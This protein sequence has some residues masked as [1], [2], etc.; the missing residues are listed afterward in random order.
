VQLKQGTSL[1]GNRNSYHICHVLGQNDLSITYL[2]TVTLQTNPPGAIEK[3]ENVVIREFFMRDFCVRE[4]SASQV[5]VPFAGKLEVVEAFR[6]RFIEEIT[7]IAKLRHPN[8]IKVIDIFE[9]N[10]SAY[11]VTEY[12]EG[13]SLRK[14]VE[15]KGA[16][17]EREALAC[18][19][20]AAYAL[21]YIHEQRIS[22]LNIEP[23]AII[24]KP[25]NSVVL[26]SFGILKR[27]KTQTL[28]LSADVSN[29]Y[30]PAEQNGSDVL[31]PCSV[32]TDVYSLAATLYKLLTTLAPPVG[33]GGTL[34]FPDHISK[35]VAAAIKKAM[36]PARSKRP[37]SMR[38]FLQLLYSSNV[39]EP[40]EEPKEEPEITEIAEPESPSLS[41]DKEEDCPKILVRIK[42]KGRYGYVDTSGKKVIPLKYGKA[43]DFSDGLALVKLNNKYC[44]IDTNGKIVISLKYDFIGDFSDG[45]ALVKLNGKYGYIDKKGRKI[46]SPKYDKAGDFSEGFAWVKLH[47]KYGYIN[48]KGKKIISLKYDKAGNFSEGIAWVRKN[49]KYGYIDTKGRE[50]IPQKYDRAG[51]FARGLARVEMDCECGY[52]DAGGREVVPL[53]YDWIWDFTGCLARAQSDGKYLWVDEQGNEYETEEEGRKA[54]CSLLCTRKESC[55]WG[56]KGA[57]FRG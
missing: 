12:V 13:S 46:I 52:I 48:T 17:P 25:D 18:I 50:V 29:P 2:A 30:T 6:N 9:Q 51:H 45:L 28:D 24:C 42:S 15:E 53:K 34:S 41:D 7:N 23:D 5:S 27:Y 14:Q 43:E 31:E 32:L 54:V 55:S 44:Y 3:K 1:Q 21:A 19:R 47:N 26:T 39:E 10:G 8:I 37:Q 57:A 22:H 38:N 56:L 16:L 33:N 35:P 40:E 11:Y 20:Q 36:N 4:E 49:G